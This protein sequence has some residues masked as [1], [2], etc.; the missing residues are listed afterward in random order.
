MESVSR[1]STFTASQ[2]ENNTGS[3]IPS[4]TQEVVYVI[5]FN[6]F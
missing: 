6:N 3:Q 2:P 1:R 4:R 5:F